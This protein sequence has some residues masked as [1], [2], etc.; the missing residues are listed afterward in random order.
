MPLRLPLF[1]L[2]GVLLPGSTFPLHV[3]E[4][5]Y[6]TLVRELREQPEPDRVFGVVAIRRG[7]EVGSDFDDTGTALHAVGCTAHLQ[8]V[9]EHPDG[10][11]DLLTVGAHR[12]AVKG[13]EHDRPY[14]VGVVELLTD[15]PEGDLTALDTAVR[16]SYD[17]Y[18]AALQAAGA[19]ELVAPTLPPDRLGLSYA[20]A[21]TVLID[22]EERQALLAAPGAGARLRSELRL[23]RREAAL[24][25]ALGAAPAPELARVPVSPN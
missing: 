11:F 13:L 9:R 21:A 16:T 5:R 22:L 1:P 24:L 10:R 25:R 8:Q 2:S 4:E 23:L 12:F 14:L 7:R 20:V 6:R 15:P 17:D 18:L 3:F 19:G